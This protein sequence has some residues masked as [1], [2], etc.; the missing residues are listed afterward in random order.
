MGETGRQIKKST[1]HEF[2]LIVT[3]RREAIARSLMTVKY[4]VL[5]LPSHLLLLFSL[6]IY[7]ASPRIGLH[8]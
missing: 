6:P 3:V 4:F 5:Y 8:A 7:L 2:S 1:D